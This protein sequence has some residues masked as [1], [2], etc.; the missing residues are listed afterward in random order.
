MNN[1]IYLDK[2]RTITHEEIG[3]WRYYADE[4]SGLEWLSFDEKNAH[5]LGVKVAGEN[6]KIGLFQNKIEIQYMQRTVSI[7]GFGSIQLSEL[8]LDEQAQFLHGYLNEAAKLSE[9]MESERLT[10]TQN[11]SLVRG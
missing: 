1:E 8:N 3:Q 7:S 10:L 9:S 2:R 11:P 6:Y 4:N 5:D